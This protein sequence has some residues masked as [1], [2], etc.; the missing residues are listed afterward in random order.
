MFVA[1]PNI[2]HVSLLFACTA[3]YQNRRLS[4]SVFFLI[5]QKAACHILWNRTIRVQTGTGGDARLILKPLDFIP[6]LNLTRFQR[7]MMT[8][9]AIFVVDDLLPKVAGQLAVS[10]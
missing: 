1:I 7:S 10:W 6:I 2:R 8:V 4:D 3:V 9:D 5:H